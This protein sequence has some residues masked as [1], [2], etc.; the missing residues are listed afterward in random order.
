M[1]YRFIG[2]SLPRTE[3]LRLM[4]GLGRYTADLAS[5]HHCRLYMVRSPHA[6]A[7]IGRMNVA[8]AQA[9]PGVRLV[10]TG[11]DPEVRDLG[12]FTSRVRRTTPDGQPNFVPPYRAL[13]REFVRFVGDP[14]AAI[15]ADTLDQAKDAAEAL[16]PEWEP[17]PA[18]T[19]TR[20]ATEPGAPLAW[21]NVPRNICFVHELGEA[22]P[23]DQ[24]LAR[25]AHVV[26]IAYPVSRVT[27]VP[28]EPRAALASYDPGNDTF[29]LYAGVQN[30][31]YIREELA[32]RVLR[33]RGNQLRVIAPDVGGGFGM[34]ESP[35]PEYPLVLIGARRLLRPVLW[36]ADRSESFLGDHHA[37][38]H[39]T[40]VTLGLDAEG[41]FV[42]LRADVISNI[43][44][45]I[46]W[47]GL[48]APVGNLGGIS[49]V[50]RTPAIH[51]RI[52]GIFSNTSPTSPYRGAGRPEATYAIERVIDVAAQRLGFD[53]IELRRRNLIAPEQMPYSTGFL[54][55]YDSGEF[56]RNMDDALALSDWAGFP[57]R[58]AEAKKRNR[59]TGIGLSNPIEIA[60]GP[61]TGP[62][63]ES[64]EIRFDSTGAVTVTLGTHSHGQGHETTFAQ[65]VSDLLGLEIKDIKVTYGDTDRLQHGTGTMGSRSVMAG[66]VVLIK[67][68]ERIVNRGK[69][70]AAAHF[71]AAETDI[72]FDAGTF[73]VAGTDRRVSLA[74]VAR[75]SYRLPARDM[76]DEL[77]LSATMMVT[78]EG[79]TF[80]NGCHVCEVEIDPETGHCAI[81]RYSVVD[82]VGR[83]VN[84]MLVDGQIHG[85]V[86][87][88][89]GQILL[90]AIQF[91]SEGQLVSGSFMDYAMPRASH[92]PNIVSKTNEVLATTNPLGVKGAGEAGTVGALA[93]VTSAIVDALSPFGVEHIEMPATSERIWRAMQPG[94]SAAKQ[95]KQDAG[96]KQHA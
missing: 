10:L 73:S 24:A 31:H 15:F 83:V 90:E 57:A 18:V 6:A 34:K 42:A 63:S 53:R 58:R 54:F 93:A 17:L 77:G 49:G 82:D 89:V 8:A 95:D 85:G 65:V 21:P 16:V 52:T 66:S 60:G 25:A 96:S 11:D 22:A 46:A 72:V 27:A 80:P 62:W 39:Y 81:V 14:V 76:G 51:G 1:A 67:T 41:T 48:L 36:A 56:E 29:T 88:G 78:P 30:P 19:E 59:L 5:G 32:E 9:C 75:L 70:I 13:S 87:Q 91:D 84:P 26:R 64:A 71:E 61:I 55:T 37:R 38:D 68:A 4:R 3:D 43:G 86:V 28:M 2:K 47:H 35:F 12:H 92:M 20:I 44:A 74:E 50:Y 23:V 45:Y 33:I 79:P 7:R 94:R 69:L 40:T